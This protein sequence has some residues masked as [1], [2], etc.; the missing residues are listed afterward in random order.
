MMAFKKK[1][2]EHDHSENKHDSDYLEYVLEDFFL[3][4]GENFSMR[5]CQKLLSWLRQTKRITNVSTFQME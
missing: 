2:S 5:K 4:K 1:L 3:K